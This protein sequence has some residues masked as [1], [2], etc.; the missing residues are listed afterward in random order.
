MIENTNQHYTRLVL[1]ND[2]GIHQDVMDII[3][4]PDTI[5]E[6]AEALRHYTENLD[7]TQD[8]LTDLQKVDFTKVDFE[9]IVRD[10]RDEL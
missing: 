1:F 6:A 2:Y 7:S 4:G 10:E 9:E 8:G 3:A 5:Q